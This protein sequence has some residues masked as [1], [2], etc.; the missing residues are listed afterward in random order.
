MG[1]CDAIKGKFGIS[2]MVQASR[3]HSSQR[4]SK[5][6]IKLEEEKKNLEVNAILQQRRR[7]QSVFFRVVSLVDPTVDF[8]LK[9]WAWI[10]K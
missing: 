10:K 9:S 1:K 7:N 2:N 6:I 3:E 8:W 4:E 5:K